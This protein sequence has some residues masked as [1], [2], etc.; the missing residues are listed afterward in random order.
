[1]KHKFHLKKNIGSIC[2][3]DMLVP[4]VKIILKIEEFSMIFFVDFWV[5]KL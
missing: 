4:N 3:I 2:N 1:M 5:Q